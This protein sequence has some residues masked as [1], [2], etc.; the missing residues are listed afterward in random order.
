MLLICTADIEDGEEKN[1]AVRNEEAALVIERD[2]GVIDEDDVNHRIQQEVSTFHAF[3]ALM[4]LQCFDA[5]G[6]MAG[7]VS[8]L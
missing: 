7:R 8:R 3:S 2:E 4:C 6:W 5:V 1:V